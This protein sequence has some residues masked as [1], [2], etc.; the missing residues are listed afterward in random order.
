MPPR[1]LGG[2]SEFFWVL[3][4]P[5]FGENKPPVKFQ[6]SN[7]LFLKKRRLARFRGK[8]WENKSRGLAY[9]FRGWRHLC[10][11]TL[12]NVGARSVNIFSLS[13]IWPF[14]RPNNPIFGALSLVQC[15]VAWGSLR[16]SSAS[17]GPPDPKNLPIWGLDNL[18]KD[19]TGLTGIGQLCW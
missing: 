12:G 17:F 14:F 4:S 7:W 1:G 19:L 2:V 3:I 6:N 9:C 8:S 11:C 5:F 10:L 15:W 18:E 16:V 13:Y